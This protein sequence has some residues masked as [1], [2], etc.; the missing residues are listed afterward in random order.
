MVFD[1]DQMDMLARMAWISVVTGPWIFG[2]QGIV[3]CSSWEPT[4]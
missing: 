4:V 3:S 1:S 2:F